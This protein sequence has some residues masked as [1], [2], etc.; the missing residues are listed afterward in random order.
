MKIKSDP[1]ESCFVIFNNNLI[2]ISST[3]TTYLSLILGYGGPN[4]NKSELMYFCWDKKN[5]QAYFFKMWYINYNLIKCKL[6]WMK[7][8]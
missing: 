5:F 1:W 6:L 7:A 3:R 8:A 2:A 4:D